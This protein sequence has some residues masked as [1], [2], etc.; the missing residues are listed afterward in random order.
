M[1]EDSRPDQGVVACGV[2]M[3]ER[4][5][6]AIWEQ[7]RTKA[8]ELLPD[9]PLEEWGDGSIPKANGIMEE[10]QAAIEAMQEPIERARERLKKRSRVDVSGCVLWT[11]AKEPRGY[12]NIRWRGRMW[13]AHRL[14]WV[15]ARGPIPDGLLVCHKCDVPSCI[16]PDHL[17]LGTHQ[18]NSD[19]KI[20]K[21]RF[22]GG[23]SG[24]RKRPPLD[25]IAA[26]AGDE[27]V[28]IV[29]HSKSALLRQRGSKRRETPH[30]SDGAC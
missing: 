30:P 1:A 9:H 11:A 27:S 3:I 12:G 20:K 25:V 17:F 6:R 24:R 19:D 14:S 23:R 2:R 7:R 21:G 26:P 13:R 5:A 15:A 4:V 28:A 22:R 18:D 29:L 16:N 8:L 10:A